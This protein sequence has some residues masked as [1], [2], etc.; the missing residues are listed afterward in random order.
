LST[1]L[2]APNI[3]SAI[4]FTKLNI[5][6]IWLGITKLT[7]K[8]TLLNLKPRKENHALIYSNVL[9]AKVNIKLIAIFSKHRFN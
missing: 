5:I 8:L 6:E 4:A 3:K 7:L 2:I 1:V 9:T